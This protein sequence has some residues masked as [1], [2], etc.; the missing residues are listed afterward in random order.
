M[1]RRSPL[2]ADTLRELRRIANQLVTADPRRLFGPDGA[3]LRLCDIP[4]DIAA[5]IQEVQ[6]DKDGP[7]QRV[8]LVDKARAARL[9]MRMTEAADGLSMDDQEQSHGCWQH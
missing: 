8:V 5:A 3:V 4:D 1:S 2:V 9:L 6:L 7:L